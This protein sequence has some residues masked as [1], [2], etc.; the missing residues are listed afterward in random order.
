MKPILL[1]S[2][3]FC[4]FNHLSAEDYQ[5]Y[6][7]QSKDFQQ[8]KKIEN[9]DSFW[10]DWIMMPWRTQWGVSFDSKMADKMASWG[11][12]GA[13]QDHMPNKEISTH[14]DRNNLRWYLDHTAGKG[15]LYLKPDLFKKTKKTDKRPVN[16]HDPKIINLLK[17]KIK[18]AVESSKLY[19]SRLA[20]ALDDEISW[21]SFTSPVK[22]DNTPEN[23]TAFS[24]WLK[25]RYITEENLY[26]QWGKYS[27]PLLN[28]GKFGKSGYVKRMA[29]PDDFQDL[30]KKPLNTWNLSPWV[31]AI[32]FMDSYYNNLVGDLVEYCNDID[33]A[34]PAGYVGG[35][36][37]APYGG[38]D[39]SKLTKKVQFLEAYDIGS[40]MEIV[41]SFNRDN[42]IA[43]V[44]T[45]FGLPNGRKIIWENWHYLAH[46]DRGLIY[47]APKWF[48]DEVP[49]KTI[50]AYGNEIQ[51]LNKKRQLYRNKNWVHDGVALYYSH[52]SIQ[53]SWFMDCQTHGRTWIN[54]SSSMNN[55]LA[56][57]IGT[58][59]AWQKILEDLKLQYNWIGYD[60]VV[61]NGI[62]EEYK[63]LILPRTL[64][65]SEAESTAI[66]SFVQ[67]GGTVIADHLTGI[68]DQHGKSHKTG[69]SLDTLFGIDQKNISPKDLF[70]GEILA[71]W[72]A[73]KNY[74]RNFVEAGGIEWPKCKKST[75]GQ[76][77]AN[78]KQKTFHQ[79]GKAHFLNVSIVNY[80]TLRDNFDQ[81]QKY[82]SPIKTILSNA[83]AVPRVTV[84]IDGKPAPNVEVTYWRSG[85]S[86]VFSVLG[87]PLRLS[88]EFGGKVFY[89]KEPTADKVTLIFDQSGKNAIDQS[90]GKKLGDGKEFTLQ[91]N[92]PRAAIMTIE[93]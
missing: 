10:S 93:F 30:Y 11:Y 16:L 65:L 61:R 42:R 86:Y 80:L 69:G 28:K 35:Q 13:F 91:W 7:S 57:T 78:R 41:R 73:D 14:L 89:G 20:Y 24:K 45:G 51:E 49:E 39:Y 43:T 32:T 31:D 79:N 38:F 60:E 25:E 52:P 67:R 62:P 29:N 2:L 33:P 66:K 53:V 50:K 56:S 26:S 72:N 40:S 71:E 68:Y 1:L 83:G 76:V 27:D 36:A 48:T 18:S 6:I 75:S 54:R 15:H 23:L 17:N 63:V 85:S 9:L 82:L 34:V 8:I 90:S 70:S 87:N 59:W 4:L 55:N 81:A 88:D 92:Q 22:W 46:G 58:N 44:K 21:S 37:P 12:T 5:S 74:R 84:L 47:W 64:A 3:I 77:I 19:K